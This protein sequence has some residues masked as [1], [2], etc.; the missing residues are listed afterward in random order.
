MISV[1]IPTFNEAQELP[2]CL[3]ALLSQAAHQLI[4]ADGGSTG[5]GGAVMRIL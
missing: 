1:V 2:G 5:V 4:V 3:A